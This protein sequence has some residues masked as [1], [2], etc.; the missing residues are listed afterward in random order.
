VHSSVTPQTGLLPDRIVIARF[1]ISSPVSNP[2]STNIDSLNDVLTRAVVR[3][4]GS[5]TMTDGNMF[6]MGHSSE[7]PIVHN[8]MYK[9]FNNLKNLVAGDEIKVYAGTHVN[10]Y[11]V[12]SVKMLNVHDA[13]AYVPFI[14][15]SKKLTL[16]TCNVR[17]EKSDRYLVE[18]EF[19][20]AQ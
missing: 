3:Y 20:S 2:V 5:G 15:G 11:R 16:V 17:A 19:V 14:T 12:T 6:I 8:P 10:T 4:N 13:N 18:A 1:G 9:V 7:L